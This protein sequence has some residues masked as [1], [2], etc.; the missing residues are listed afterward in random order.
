MHHIVRISGE[1]KEAVIFDLERNR[2]EEED[3]EASELLN[4]VLLEES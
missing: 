2:E 3:K 1:E 4:E